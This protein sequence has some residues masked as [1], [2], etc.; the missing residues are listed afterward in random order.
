MS[1]ETTSPELTVASNESARSAQ[2]DFTTGPIHTHLIRL[3][4]YMLMGFVSIM[5]A[6]LMETVYIG[7]VG[8]QELAAISFTF[9][10]VMILQGVS[11]GLSVGASSVVA[12]TIGTGDMKK[13]RRLITHCFVLVMVLILVFAV[14]AYIYVEPFFTLLGA[15][16]HILPLSV[17]YMEIW[18]LGLPFFTVALVG[19]TLMRAAGDA[20]TPGY[21]MTIGS[22]LHVVIAPFFIF[23]LGPA[24]EMGLEGAAVG[25][26]LARTVSFCLYTYYIVYR[27]RLLIASLVGLWSS[28]R[29]ILHVGLPA[30]ASNLIGPVSMG[31]ITRLLAGH[32]AEVVAGYGVASRVESMVVMVIIALGMSVA[33]F[34]GQNWGAGHHH[35]VRDALSLSNRFSLAWGLFA[36][37]M[38]VMFAE[39]LVSLINDDPLVV[40]AATTYLII[41]PISIGCMGVM[42]I[43]T[44]SFNALGKPLPPLVISIN[45]TLVVYIPLAILGDYL[46]GYTGIFI[47]MAVTTILLG[48]VS[49]YWLN[50]VIKSRIDS[51]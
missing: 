33:P 9:P 35:R 43:S 39:V 6:S 44:Q 22:A 15:Q 41:V 8:T 20:V 18:L 40:Q 45:Q 3:T 34:V 21:L 16:P 31:V 4:G 32:G 19:S 51:V 13:V 1:E 48:A 23:G 26:V 47:A 14:I 30:I 12:R 25:F 11:M 50:H 36:F 49:W 17:S 46:W 7:V 42:M 27:D 38:M 2:S 10:L 24:P 37:I 5:T 28:V 29:A